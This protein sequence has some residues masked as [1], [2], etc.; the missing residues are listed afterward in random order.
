MQSKFDSIDFVQMVWASF[1]RNPREIR[2]FRHPDDLLRYLAALARHKVIAE[3][4]RRIRSTKYGVTNECSLTDSDG[5]DDATKSPEMSPSHVAMA[6]EEWERLMQ[7][8]SKRD[9][10]ILVMRF[11]GATYVDISQRLGI[12]E[13]TVRKIVER[14]TRSSRP[15]SEP[16]T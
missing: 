11:G 4:R 15:E 12:N 2:S 10:E 8:Q 3:Y 14:L 6:R 9:Q 5:E 7:R 1:F 13:R 16:E